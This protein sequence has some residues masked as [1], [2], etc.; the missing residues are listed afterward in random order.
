M[1]SEY[2]E[3]LMLGLTD[4]LS[5][6]RIQD[7][8]SATLESTAGA[9]EFHGP[10][11]ELERPPEPSRSASLTPETASK[12][13]SRSPRALWAPMAPRELSENLEEVPGRKF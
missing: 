4:L 7:K 12:L 6:K 2:S 10:S 13:T 5:M 1:N 8:V 11:E 3:Q 9:G